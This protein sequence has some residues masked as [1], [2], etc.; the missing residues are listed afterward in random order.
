MRSTLH[1]P[2]LG[3]CDN[4]VRQVAVDVSDGETLAWQVR[5]DIGYDAVTLKLSNDEVALLVCISSCCVGDLEAQ[6]GQRKS[7]VLCRRSDPQRPF[8][9]GRATRIK[10][11][12]RRVD[13]L[14][15]TFE[16]Q[17]PEANV[18]PLARAI[19]NRLLEADVLAAAKE[20]ER[21]EGSHRVRLISAGRR[22]PFA[23]N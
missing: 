9:V 19:A 13:G 14:L 22:G 3:Y 23:T 15:D 1:R 2:K 16:G 4:P 7:G 20:V 5:S 6:S 10:P 18:V 8:V 12:R 17:S 21:A 11:E